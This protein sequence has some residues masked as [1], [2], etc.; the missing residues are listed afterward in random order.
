MKISMAYEGYSGKEI[1]E[2]LINKDVKICASS[3]PDIFIFCDISFNEFQKLWSIKDCKVEDKIFLFFNIPSI[4]D[5]F[6]I[7][8]FIKKNNGLFLSGSVVSKYSK[9]GKEKSIIYYSGDKEAFVKCNELISALSP[10]K[11]LGESPVFA[12]LMNFSAIG[13]HYSFILAFYTGIAMCKKYGFD[14]NTYIYHTMKAMPPLSEGAYRNIW[15]GLRDPRTFE[16]VDDVIHGMEMLVCLMKKTKGDEEIK[17][18]R[19]RQLLLNHILYNH[20]NELMNSFQHVK[21]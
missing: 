6:E 10:G 3:D 19:E 14:V 4:D 11:F 15:A 17:D 7:G 8:K 18:N 12:T 16:D 21:E 13:I 1:Y 5:S 2:A 20:W 9:L